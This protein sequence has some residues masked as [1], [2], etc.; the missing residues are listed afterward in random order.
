MGDNNGRLQNLI[1]FVMIIIDKEDIQKIY[2]EALVKNTKHFKK[3]KIQQNALS[4]SG[5]RVRLYKIDSFY[6]QIF[7]CI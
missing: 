5:R 2:N 1:I 7:V 6:I 4:L 3:R